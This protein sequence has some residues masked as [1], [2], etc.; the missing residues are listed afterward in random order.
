[1]IWKLFVSVMAMSDTGSVSTAAVVTDYVD[2]PSCMQAAA[3]YGQGHDLV[4]YGHKVTIK[5]SATCAPQ[6]IAYRTDGI[7]PPVAGMLRGFLDGF[8]QR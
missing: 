5:V 6:Q 7:P 4:A 3:D 2:Q 1:M 8:E